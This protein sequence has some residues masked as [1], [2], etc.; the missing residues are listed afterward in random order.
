MSSLIHSLI[1]DDQTMVFFYL[2]IIIND[3]IVIINGE[4]WPF[5]FQC[6]S[7]ILS[8][9]VLNSAFIFLSFFFSFSFSLTR[10]LI[11]FISFSLSLS[12]LP[13]LCPPLSLP[14]S[15]SLSLHSL[16]PYL[17]FHFPFSI[18]CKITKF[19]QID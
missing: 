2:F 4:A 15:L 13:S 12:L 10:L 5:F 1:S 19:Y 3:F 9:N 14:L 16:L 11:F 17:L 18:I 6:G 7:K 8:T